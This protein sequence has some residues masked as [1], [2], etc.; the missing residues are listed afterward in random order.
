MFT[1]QKFKKQNVVLYRVV[2]SLLLLFMF[3]ST[4]PG[5]YGCASIPPPDKIEIGGEIKIGPDGCEWKVEAGLV[6]EF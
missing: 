5:T 4:L 3:F 2:C 1:I 6:W